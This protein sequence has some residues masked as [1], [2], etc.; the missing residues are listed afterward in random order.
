MCKHLAKDL[1]V[2]LNTHI[3]CISFS[4]QKWSLQTIDNQVF[5]DYDYLILAIPAP[6]ALAL[7]PRQFQYT[8][9]LEQR[10]MSGCFTLMLGLNRNL[11]MQFDAAVVKQSIISWIAK[12]IPS[13]IDRMSLA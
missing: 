5:N 6:Q 10:S 7:I 8:E 1:N 9:L 11:N 4:Q 13:Q 2:L 12:I 3:N